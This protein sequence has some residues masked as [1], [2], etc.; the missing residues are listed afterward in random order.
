MFEPLR[1]GTDGDYFS[2]PSAEDV[3]EKVYEMIHFFQR[4]RVAR[5]PPHGVERRRQGND[6]KQRNFSVRRPE[7]ENPAVA[8]G[9]ANRT[10]GVR[11]QRDV[12]KL[13]RDGDGASA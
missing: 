13:T 2:K 12:A 7:P 1:Y 3:F 6:P 9:H 4:R 8:G 5:E 10:G 11:A